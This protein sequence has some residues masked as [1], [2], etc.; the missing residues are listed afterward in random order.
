MKKN[1]LTTWTLSLAIVVAIIAG[2]FLIESTNAQDDPNAEWHKGLPRQHNSKWLVHDLRRPKPAIVSPGR[3]P[4]DAPADAVVLFD[5]KDLSQWKSQRGEGPA[6]WK[7]ENGYMEV[8]H[9]GNIITREDFGDCQLHLEY[10]A[11]TPPQK[12]DQGRGNS[13]II[14]MAFNGVGY[15]V[16]VL[17]NYDNRTYADGYVGSVYGQHP[18]MVNP[19]RKPGEWQTYEIVFRAPRFKD[20]EVV[21]PGRVTVFLNGVLVL[22][23][24]QIYGRTV[25]RQLSR[26]TPHAPTG[27]ILLQDHGDK[28]SA[29]F[30]NIW[31]RRLDLSKTD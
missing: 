2:Q 25:W 19:G 12:S 22:H 10:M 26:Y 9:T 31:I 15:E 18:P 7:V 3:T 4:R 24:A 1:S 20:K 28:Q 27:P 16:Q 11:P 14:F 8:N 23:N 29:R 13:G 30:R 6:G 21:E 5:G 17:D